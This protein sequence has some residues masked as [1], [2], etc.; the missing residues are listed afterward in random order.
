MGKRIYRLLWT[1]IIS[2]I[3]W[4]MLLFFSW[5]HGFEKAALFGI[6]LILFVVSFQE[7]G[8]KE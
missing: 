2:L 6:A 7:K 5:V 8:D 4:S 3:L 1:V